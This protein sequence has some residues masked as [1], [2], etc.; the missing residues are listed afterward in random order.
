MTASRRYAAGGARPAVTR[1]QS[2]VALRHRSRP[3]RD[4]AVLPVDSREDNGYL[5]TVRLT[6]RGV[7][8]A[9]GS[10]AGDCWRRSRRTATSCARGCGR[11]SGPLGDA[12]NAGQIYVTLARLE[13]AGLVACERAGRPD[14][15]GPQGLRADRRRAAAGRRLAG[16]GQLAQARPGGIPP[17]ADRGRGGRP[18]RPAGD[19]RRAAPRAA[20]PAAGRAARRDGR[21]A[22]A[23][24][25]RCCWR[26]SCSGCRRTCA[27]WRHASGPG[28]AGRSRVMSDTRD[29]IDAARPRA[30]Q[31]VRQR[32]RAGPRGRRRRPGRRRRARRSR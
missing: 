29:R 18:R 3:H 32:R 13:K 15:P 7:S 22:T 2:V 14:R 8:R 9:A 27:G 31:G 28:P 10:G 25:P 12:M 5:L 21:A 16:R 20:A 6:V 11:R 23:R 1:P 17:Q 30:A 4:P 24:T 26:A 19:R